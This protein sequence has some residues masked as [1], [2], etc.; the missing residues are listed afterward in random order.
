VAPWEPSES[1]DDV[2][3]TRPDASTSGVH[4]D[5]T[6]RRVLVTGASSGIGA[7][8]SRVVVGCG[9]SVAMLARRAER[10]DELS[11]ELGE[12]AVGIPADVT[13][14]DALER[15]IDEAASSLGGLD[16]VV[17]VAGKSMAG[18]V[19]TGTPA[20][21]RALF[22][23]NLVAP[24][25]TVKFG[26]GHFAPVG[27]RDVVVIG[28]TGAITPMPGVAIYGASKRGLRAACESLR[29]ELAPAGI[30]VTQV[31]PGM[32]DTEGLTIEGM[33]LDGDMPDYPIPM[34]APEMGPASPEV[35]ATTVAFAIGLPEGIAIN[36]LVVR[37]TGQYNP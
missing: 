29:L 26:V 35:L 23:L 12:R 36:E 10:L 24:L 6:G 32:F 33:V 30:N 17:A 14:L 4:V 25:A 11:A 18:S 16:G 27:R 5:L 21:W 3:A 9:G 34:F 2:K 31:M 1:I 22:D 7:A 37:P 13:D 15:A 8:I 28:S 20:Q 19:M